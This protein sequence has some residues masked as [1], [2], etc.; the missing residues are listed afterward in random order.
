V[1]RQKEAGLLQ[2]L[3][4]PERPSVSVSMD[5]VVGFLKVDGM[6][7]VMVVVD[8][9]LKYAIFM[10]T[11][12]VCTTEVAASLFYKHM[13][14]YFGV[15]LYVVSDRDVRFTGRLWIVLFGL[16]GTMLKFSTTNHLQT[17]GHTEKI[18]ALLEDYL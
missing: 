12:S 14:K 15:L 10:A 2:P 9:F 11:P 1:L 5:L 6:D 18:N 16:M 17:D 4:I 13:V 3:P 7:A 8:K